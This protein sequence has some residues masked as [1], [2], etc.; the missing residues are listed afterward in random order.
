MTFLWKWRVAPLSS[1]WGSAGYY[2]CVKGSIHMLDCL[3]LGI[4]L[5]GFVVCMGYVAFCARI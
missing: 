1:L 2:R 5:G 3:Y 4:G